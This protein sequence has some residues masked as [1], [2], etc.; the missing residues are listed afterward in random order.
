[1]IAERH[2]LTA[3]HVV[4]TSGSME[5]LFAAAAAFTK[6]GRIVAPGLTFG[7]HLTVAERM[8]GEVL[9][10]P[11]T[12]EMDQD[13]ERMAAVTD[14][15]TSLVYVCNPNNPTG[16]T[17]EGGRMRAF[18]EAVSARA[19]VMVDEAYNELTDNPDATSMVDLVR[20]GENVIITR[21]FSKLYGLAGLRVGYALAPPHLAEMLK[22]H[23][24]TSPSVVGAAAALA[25][26]NDEAFL[27]YSKSKI[28]EGRQMVEA[29]F[30]RLE[31]PH[32]PSQTNFVYA[33]IGRDADAFQAKMRAENVLIRGV[34]EPYKTWS[35]VSM[36][37]L[38]DLER[39]VQTFE[40]VYTLG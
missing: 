18:C 36:G 12:G 22:R 17:V 39:F 1:M 19:T 24:M 38:E 10:V 26:Y 3:D 9:R 28:V 14:S 25:S 33:D 13:L 15:M 37:K 6:Y 7:P 20:R 32:V 8:G 29:L 5:C 11:L 30:D 4:L 2:G 21:T 16:L 23:A 34:Y 35:R 40:R 31:I 27:A